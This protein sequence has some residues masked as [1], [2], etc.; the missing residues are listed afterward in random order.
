MSNDECV[1]PA[2]KIERKKNRS[3][4][5]AQHRIDFHQFFPSFA[6]DRQR[7]KNAERICKIQKNQFQWPAGS[8]GLTLISN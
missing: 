2:I 6:F 3:M 4:N 8:L 5:F 7:Q 1:S